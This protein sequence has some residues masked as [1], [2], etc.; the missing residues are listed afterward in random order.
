MCGLAGIARREPRGVSVETLDRMGMALRHRGPDGY[1][2]YAE[3]RVGLAHVR[4]SIIDVAGGAQPLGNE[5]G[6]VLIVYN[7]EVYNYLELKVELEAAGHRFRTR[8]DTEV[9][10]HAYEQW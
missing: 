6:S 4:L 8:C 7:G 1:G 5:D 9:L 3:A 2:R 10:V